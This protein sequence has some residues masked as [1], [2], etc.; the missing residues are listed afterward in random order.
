[1]RYISSISYTAPKDRRFPFNIAAFRSS[2]DLELAPLTVFVGE[3]MLGKS[4]LLKTLALAMSLE[5]IGGP[6]EQK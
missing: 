6:I 2:F 4:T 3:N 1:M 5:F